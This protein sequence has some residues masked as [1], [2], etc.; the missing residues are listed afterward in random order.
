MQSGSYIP[1]QFDLCCAAIRSLVAA[2]RD[3]AKIH[4]YIAYFFRFFFIIFR[5]I[6]K[7]IGTSVGANDIGCYILISISYSTY[8][9]Y[10]K[11]I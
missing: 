5:H 2:R 7:P 6:K 11:L 4:I 9:A 1:G 10:M 8:R 3:Y